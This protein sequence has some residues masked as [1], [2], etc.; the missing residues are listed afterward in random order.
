MQVKLS[1]DLSYIHYFLE[2]CFNKENV[3]DLNWNDALTKVRYCVGPS[4]SQDYCVFFKHRTS[5]IC[6]YN[7]RTGNFDEY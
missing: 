7:V 6:L 4:Y 3:R 2:E 1:K 5:T